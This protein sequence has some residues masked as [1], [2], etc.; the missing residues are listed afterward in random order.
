MQSDHLK[1]TSLKSVATGAIRKRQM[2]ECSTALPVICRTIIFKQDG[3][4]F[5]IQE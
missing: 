1:A 5:K 3:I 4:S 2:V